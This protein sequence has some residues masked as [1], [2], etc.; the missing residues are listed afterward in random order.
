MNLNMEIVILRHG[1]PDISA[2]EKLK[3]REMREWIESYDSAGIDRTHVPPVIAI[4]KAAQCKAVVCS[5]LK[6]SVESAETLKAGHVSLSDAVFREFSL[7]YME[8]HSFRLSPMIWAAFFR[9][10]WFAGFSAG[11]ESFRASKRR[12]KRG[13]DKLKEVAAERGSVLF[14]GHGLYNY[15]LSKELRSTGWQGPMNPGKQYWEFGVYTYTIACA[16]DETVCI[17][18]E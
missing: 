8:W 5:D 18:C 11:G 17:P 2:S 12:V 3:A 14:V 7:P 6:R 1:K 16:N 13:A 9:M 4:E 15:F 10:L